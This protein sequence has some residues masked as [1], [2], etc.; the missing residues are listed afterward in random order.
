M[1]KPTQE[2]LQELFDYIPF[3][4]EFFRRVGVRG[5]NGKAGSSA[6]TMTYQGYLTISIRQVTY[7][8]HH[9][10]WLY[11]HGYWPTMLDHKNGN[12]A[13]NRIS[14]LREATSEDN[15]RNRICVNTTGFKGVTKVGKRW[16]ARTE[17]GGKI[18]HLG[19]FDTAEEAGAAYDVYVS[20]IAGEFHRA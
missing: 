1:N 2:E 9:L 14:N 8:A 7:R 18:K 5:I 3:T 10:A 11:V 13:D 4:G 19:T 6:G 12:R 17:I 15:N 20:V 16:K